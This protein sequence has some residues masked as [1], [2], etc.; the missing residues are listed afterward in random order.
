MTIE[1]LKELGFIRKHLFGHW[2]IVSLYAKGWRKYIMFPMR[3]NLPQAESEGDTQ[4][5]D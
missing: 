1:K 4:H 3:I 2:Y 5:D